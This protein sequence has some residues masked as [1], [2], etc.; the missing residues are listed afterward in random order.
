MY[1]Y[2]YNI[3]SGGPAGHWPTQFSVWPTKFISPLSFL[4]HPFFVFGPPSF[5]RS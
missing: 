1:M 5:A 4:A 2:I 3:Y